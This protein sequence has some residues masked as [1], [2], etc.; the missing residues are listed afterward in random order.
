MGRKKTENSSGESEL[1][2]RPVAR[3][4][5]P[6]KV[7]SR[8][9]DIE[10][11]EF[12]PIQIKSGSLKDIFC[13]YTYDHTIQQN[14]T[15]NVICKSHLPIHDDLKNAFGRFNAHLAVI[16]EEIHPD[17]ITDIDNLPTL[18]PDL[19]VND[20]SQDP[21]AVK[22]S[23]YSVSSVRIVGNG[24]NEGV[25]LTGMKQLTTAALVGL[26]TPVTKFSSEYAFV[27][28]LR[29]ATSDL[30]SEI[31]QYMNGKQAPSRQTEMDFGDGEHE[32]EEEDDF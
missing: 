6:S 30:V 10:E 7:S 32:E 2:S 1:K 15:N 17:E 25:I 31:E 3:R 27:P 14:T 5:I 24:E 4:K 18:N 20:P 16:C 23:R 12:K 13:H 8:L 29:I 19:P 21:M 9:R 11:E 28:E 26:E 22:I